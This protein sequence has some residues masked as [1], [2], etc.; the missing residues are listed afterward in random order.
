MNKPLTATETFPERVPYQKPQP[1]D[2]RADL[3][4]HD[5]MAMS[6]ASD[7]RVWVPLA[8]HVA[9]RPLQFN[10]TQ[11]QYSH[12][13]RVT[14]AGMIARHRHSGGVHA[15]VFKGRW[16]YL[17]HDWV[18]EEGSYI[19]E[20]PGETHTLVVPDGCT[21]MITLFQVT[22]SLMYVDPQGASTGYDDVFTRLDK[23]RAH[24]TAVGL[25]ERYVEQ[26]IR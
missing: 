10:V 9:V 7:P 20:P 5:A 24:Y 16:Q 23:A 21:E 18:A 13:M 8:P 17:E 14:K 15:W 1:R 12:V 3:V 19:W 22:G 26:F 25:G 4:I 11:G 2:M 6:A